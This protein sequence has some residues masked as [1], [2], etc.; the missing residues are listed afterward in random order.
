M[1]A[2]RYGRYVQVATYDSTPRP[3][4]IKVNIIKEL[5]NRAHH[6]IASLTIDG[7]AENEGKL[8]NALA[9][10]ARQIGADSILI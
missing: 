8:I 4:T 10:K 9:W 6:I 3:P 1:P 2:V 7:E 5:P